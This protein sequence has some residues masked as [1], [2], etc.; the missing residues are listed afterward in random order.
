MQKQWRLAA[1]PEGVPD[2]SHFELFPY[3]HQTFYRHV[4]ATSCTPFASRAID[5]GLPGVVVAMARHSEAQLAPPSGAMSADALQRIKDEIAEVLQNRCM[6]TGAADADHSQLLPTEVRQQVMD[7]M[8]AWWKLTQQPEAKLQYWTHEEKG[9]GAGL[10]HTPLDTDV[11]YASDG[12][13]QFSTN[14]SLRDVEP[15]VPI[16]LVNYRDEITADDE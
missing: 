13:K 8:E 6:A 10:L 3:W 7:L 16:R 15:T 4:E 2:R 9:S 12:Y 5:R 11:L 14:W 1:R